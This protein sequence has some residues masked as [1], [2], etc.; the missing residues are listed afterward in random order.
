MDKT[1]SQEEIE[2]RLKEQIKA[3][4]NNRDKMSKR[5]TTQ[6]KMPINKKINFLLII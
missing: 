2:N 1:F 3:A 6:T 4:S 5:K